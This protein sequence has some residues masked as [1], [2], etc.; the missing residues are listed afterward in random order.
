MNEDRR[1]DQESMGVGLGDPRMD[2]I[3]LGDMVPQRVGGHLTDAQGFFRFS[4]PG[5]DSEGC[6]VRNTIPKMCGVE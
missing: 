2:L 6:T 4:F 5:Y 1:R 3:Y